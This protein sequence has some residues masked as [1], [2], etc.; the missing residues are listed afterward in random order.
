M[1]T[2]NS[3]EFSSLMGRDAPKHGQYMTVWGHSFTWT[4]SHP[5]VQDVRRMLFS[6]DKLANDALDRLDRHLPAGTKEAKC[7]H[8]G[9]GKEEGKKKKD[10]YS[11]LQEHAANDEVLGELWH[12]V[13]TVPDWVDWEQIARGQEVVYQFSGQIVLGVRPD[14][15]S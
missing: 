10:L 6:Y 1:T 12:N 5:T 9:V 2:L 4:S 14:S 7:P 3:D 13:S 15:P 11:L 8:D